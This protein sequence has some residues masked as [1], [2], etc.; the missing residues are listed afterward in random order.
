MFP[1]RGQHFAQERKLPV[2]DFC[3]R[4][5]GGA[6]GTVQRFQKG[7]LRRG[8]DGM[9]GDVQRLEQCQSFFIIGAGGAIL[10]VFGDLR[11]RGSAILANQAIGGA[12][13]V[14]GDGGLGLGGGV[15]NGYFDFGG[16]AVIADS[17]ISGNQATGGAGGGTGSTSF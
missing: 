9:L 13:G 15:F 1:V 8:G 12:G 6:A 5:N 2:S 14:G 7:P 10:N 3:Q 16:T 4:R 17:L 11:I